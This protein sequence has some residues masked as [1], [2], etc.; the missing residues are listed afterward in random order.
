M[1]GENEKNLEIHQPPE[2]TQAIK[3]IKAIVLRETKAIAIAGTLA[4]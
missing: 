4:R 3:A 1:D 2:E